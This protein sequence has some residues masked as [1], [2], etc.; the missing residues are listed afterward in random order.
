MVLTPLNVNRYQ[1]FKNDAKFV[2]INLAKNGSGKI[3]QNFA[4]LNS[5]PKFREINNVFREI[6]YFA[7]LWKPTFVAILAGSK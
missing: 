7:K 3:S 4:K 1:L 5:L 2:P 6:S